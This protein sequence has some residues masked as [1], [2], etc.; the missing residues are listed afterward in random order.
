MRLVTTFAQQKRHLRL[1]FDALRHHFHVQAVRHGDH[2]SHHG[3]GCGVIRTLH[4]EAAVDLQAVGLVVQDVL[5]VGEAGAEVIDR[6][7]H[8]TL[9]QAAEAFH[10]VH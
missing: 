6:N 8:T 1:G 5:E 7:A 2:A 4:G 9:A 10:G 3:A